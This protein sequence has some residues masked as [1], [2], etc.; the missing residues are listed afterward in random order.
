MLI[1][2]FGTAVVEITRFTAGVVSPGLLPDHPHLPPQE[3][4][5]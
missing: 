2:T 3:H 4:K 1:K 5:P